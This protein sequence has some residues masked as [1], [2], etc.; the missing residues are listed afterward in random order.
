MGGQ[1]TAAGFINLTKIAK[2]NGY[3][4]FSMFDDLNTLK[5]QFLIILM[6]MGQEIKTRI[7]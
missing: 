3:N 4:V 1:E 6:L 2:A 7:G 5:K